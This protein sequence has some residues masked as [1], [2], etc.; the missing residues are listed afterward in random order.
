MPDN[1]AAVVKVGDGEANIE[2]AQRDKESRHAGR[3]GPDAVD[4]HVD[5]GQEREG[6]QERAQAS[7]LHDHEQHKG[8]LDRSVLQDRVDPE[9]NKKMAM[10]RENRTKRTGNRGTARRQLGPA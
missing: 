9:E 10:S 4:V 5:A 7:A 2:K 8:P 1:E 3:D 6:Q